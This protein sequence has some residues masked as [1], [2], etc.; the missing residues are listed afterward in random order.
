MRILRF[1]SKAEAVM[2]SCGK[3]LVNKVD[4]SRNNKSTSKGFCF[5]IGDDPKEALLYLGGIVNEEIC[6]VFEADADLFRHSRG[7][8]ADPFGDWF[9]TVTKEELCITS[10]NRKSVRPVMAYLPTMD[11]LEW[12]RFSFDRAVFLL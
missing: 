11:G 6:V 7:V 8:Y 4:Y 10:Y 2:L 9:D 3:T 5:W 1:M 12:E